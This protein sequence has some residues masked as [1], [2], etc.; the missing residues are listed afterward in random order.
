MYFSFSHIYFSFSSS[1]SIYFD[2]STS[3]LLKDHTSTVRSS[4][5][6]CLRIRVA[7]SR[8]SSQVAF[9]LTGYGVLFRSNG[10]AHLMLIASHDPSVM[11]SDLEAA[12]SSLRLH[13]KRQQLV[14]KFQGTLICFFRFRN[15]CF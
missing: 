5:S 1:S 4:V 10:V 12:G 14:K 7:S 8:K 13:F 11:S 3:F 6:H 2:I 15:L 9:H